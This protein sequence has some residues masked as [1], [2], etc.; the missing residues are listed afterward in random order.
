MPRDKEPS[1]NEQPLPDDP[2]RAASPPELSDH[3]AAELGGLDAVLAARASSET[4]TEEENASP[5]TDHEEA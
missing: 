1:P 3:L 5:E 4:S 2:R